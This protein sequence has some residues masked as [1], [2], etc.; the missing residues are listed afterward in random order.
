MTP[1]Q[2]GRALQDIRDLHNA[3]NAYLSRTRSAMPKHPHVWWLWADVDGTW[4]VLTSGNTEEE[5][6]QSALRLDGGYQ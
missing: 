5:A 1:E 2:K 6:L 4:M 3:P